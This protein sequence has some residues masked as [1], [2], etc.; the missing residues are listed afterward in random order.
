M[1]RELSALKVI[2]RTR[3]LFC[4][5]SIMFY[6]L[7]LLQKL[8]HPN[9]CELETVSLHEY[10]LYLLFP[11]IEK[12]LHDYL[13]AAASGGSGSLLKPHQVI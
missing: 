10:K 11:Y 1:M 7:M 13:N 6:V 3:S 12:T 4:F 8:N 9:I 5:S 2:W